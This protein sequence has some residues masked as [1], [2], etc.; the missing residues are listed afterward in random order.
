[1][2]AVIAVTIVFAA[3]VTIPYQAV[4]K[5]LSDSQIQRILITESQMNYPGNCPCP[6]N[7]DRA[8]RRCGKRSA[9]LKAG[10]YSPLCYNSDV[11]KEMIK[12][13]RSSR[14]Q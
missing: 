1:M 12:N 7:R 8:G 3:L 10:G 2:N 6:D 13:Y 14:S 9:Y 11:T 4:A 5:E